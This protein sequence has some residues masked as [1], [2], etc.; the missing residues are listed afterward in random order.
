VLSITWGT[1][2]AQLVI[3][4]VLIIIVSKYAVKP[5]TGM[6]KKRE[7]YITEQITSAEN[8]RKEAEQLLA[9]QRAELDKARQEAKDLIERAKIQKDKEAERIIMEAKEQSER[10]IQEAKLEIQREREK[11]VAALR[12][13]VGALTVQLASKL[14]EEKL[15]EKGQSKL[16]DRYFEQVGRLQ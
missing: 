8:N 2:I 13:E 15:D 14:L 5:V 6:I 10:M 4:G 12:N 16:V 1:V 11:A 7:E 9:Q 3:V